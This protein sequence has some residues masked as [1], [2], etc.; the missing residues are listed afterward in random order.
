MQWMLRGYVGL[1]N[2]T[3]D[4]AWNHQRRWKK[5]KLPHWL[6]INRGRGFYYDTPLR[7]LER[8]KNGRFPDFAVQASYCAPE[9]EDN[10]VAAIEE[11]EYFLRRLGANSLHLFPVNWSPRICWGRHGGTE[12]ALWTKKKKSSWA[13]FIFTFIVATI[14]SHFRICKSGQLG[15]GDAPSN[16]RD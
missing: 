6:S 12:Q 1:P 4:G 3:S 10:G 14:Q 7:I 13:F 2:C 8:I 11:I 15:M 5:R 9:W 16:N